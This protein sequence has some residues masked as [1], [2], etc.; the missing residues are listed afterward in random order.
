M[1]YREDYNDAA[2]YLQALMWARRRRWIIL[3]AVAFTI[4]VLGISMFFLYFQVIDIE[5]EGNTR[6]TDAEI[7]DY[8]TNGILGDNTIVLGFRYGSRFKPDLPFVESMDISVTSHDSIRIRVYERALAGYVDFLGN[9]MYFSRDGTVVETSSKRLGG[10]PEVTGL[11]FDYV[12][13]YQPLPVKDP[14][15]FSRILTLTQLLEKYEL[16]ADRIYFDTRNRVSV[17]F[18]KIRATLGN[19]DYLDEKLDNISRILPQIAGEEGTLQL[20]NYSAETEYIS[21]L[22][23]KGKKAELAVYSSQEVPVVLK[24]YGTGGQAGAPQQEASPASD[25]NSSIVEKIPQEGE[26]TGTPESE[27]DQAGGWESIPGS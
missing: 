23:K 22:R 3:G 16:S 7:A 19:E 24:E 20:A 11:S 14:E 12:A 27:A 4:L 15:V 6:Y 8:V 5:V 2:S 10:I 25:E 17:Y 9:L 1:I 18:G 26:E 21:F 13:L